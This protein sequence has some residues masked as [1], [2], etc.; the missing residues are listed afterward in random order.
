MK[1]EIYKENLKYDNKFGVYHKISFN[2]EL[3]K[4]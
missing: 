4:L 2:D 3:Q 1:Q